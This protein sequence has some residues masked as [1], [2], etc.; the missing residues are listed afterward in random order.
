MNSTDQNYPEEH[1]TL[2]GA[3]ATGHPVNG[4]WFHDDKSKDPAHIR[5]ARSKRLHAAL[6]WVLDTLEQRGRFCKASS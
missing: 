6:D 2:R 3:P 1:A 4:V 5:D